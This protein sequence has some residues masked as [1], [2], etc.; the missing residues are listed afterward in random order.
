M[1]VFTP[2]RPKIRHTPRRV[3]TPLE[4]Q[5]VRVQID[6]RVRIFDIQ[7]ASGNYHGSTVINEG[8]GCTVAVPNDG[9]DCGGC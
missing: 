5:E 7:M 9:G 4:K 2:N 3:L 1:P 8:C 6:E